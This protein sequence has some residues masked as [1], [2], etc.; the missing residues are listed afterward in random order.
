MPINPQVSTAASEQ[1]PLIPVR[2][3]NEYVYCPRLAYLMWVQQEWADS[4]A[5]VEGR[6]HH[7]HVDG[8]AKEKRDEDEHLIHA[9]S[10]TLSVEIHDFTQAAGAYALKERA[11]KA[12]IATFERRMSQE[13]THPL[14]GYTCSYRRMLEVQARL[15][16][17]YL[18]GEIDDFPELLTR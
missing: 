7:R 1:P 14:F 12:F 17:R 10:I 4:D 13:I 6:F 11:R 8:P 3:V 15:F 2:M 9:R 16:G 18:T 5:T